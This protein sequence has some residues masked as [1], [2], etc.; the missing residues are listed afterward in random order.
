MFTRVPPDEAG[1][2]AAATGAPEAEGERS[3]A[4]L[5]NTHALALDSDEEGF[6]YF[7]FSTVER[8]REVV[9]LFIY[10]ADQLLYVDH[11]SK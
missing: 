3:V 5:W 9:L 1:G 6:R 7:I 2:G 11:A 8:Y 10:S 4:W